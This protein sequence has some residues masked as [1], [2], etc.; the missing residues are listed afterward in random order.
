MKITEFV[1]LLKPAYS[2][3]GVYRQG[4]TGVEKLDILSRQAIWL[5]G[6]DLCLFFKCSLSG[7]PQKFSLNVINQKIKEQSPFVHTGFYIEQV[8]DEAM[9]WLWDSDKQIE[10][11]KLLSSKESESYLVIPEH[12][13]LDVARD[14]F[15]ERDCDKR[16]LIEKWDNGTLE[17]FR[18]VE[19]EMTELQRSTFQKRFSGEG[20]S[21]FQ[22][23]FA[24]LE[25]PRHLAHWWQRESLKSPKGAIV[26]LTL[27]CL[28]TVT[29]LFGNLISKL[30]ILSTT[31]KAVNELHQDLRPEIVA[32][33]KFLHLQKVNEVRRIQ[34]NRVDMLSV[35]AE[36]EYLLGDSYLELKEWQLEADQL[37]VVLTT[38]STSN[39]RLLEQLNQSDL[40]QDTKAELGTNTDT[41]IIYSTLT[42]LY[43]STLRFLQLTKD[44]SGTDQG[45]VREL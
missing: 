34:L 4:R 6:A 20:A 15:I 17:G 44:L 16:V 9:V 40:F 39:R 31:E 12:L 24:Y 10:T 38:S 21:W 13:M 43:E 28:F 36:F 29:C 45:A 8:D 33:E 26:I 37:K 32:R 7:I 25:S 22:K 11:Q 30:Y 3:T 5:I 35:I 42:P 18:C 23:D 19:G 41:V 2:K 14:G 1:R 27:L